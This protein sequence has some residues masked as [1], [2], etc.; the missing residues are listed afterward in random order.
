MFRSSFAPFDLKGFLTL[1]TNC[2]SNTDQFGNMFKLTNMSVLSLFVLLS[3]VLFA[4]GQKD[5]ENKIFK[6]PLTDMAASAE[7]VETSHYFPDHPDN[8]FPIGETFT[9]LCH[10]SNEGHSLYNVSA[11]M[12]SLNSPMDFRH[13]FQNYSYKPIGMVVKA[14]EE[15]SLE[16]SIP[17]HADL[18]PVEYQLAITVFYESETESFSTTFFNQ[19]CRAFQLPTQ[20]FFTNCSIF[21]QT[22]ELY[23]PVSEYDLE[24]VISVLVSIIFSVAVGILTL[25]ACSPDTKIPLFSYNKSEKNLNSYD[26]TVRIVLLVVCLR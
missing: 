8:K 20:M 6:H 14:G 2:V 10:F 18:E 12:G 4:V 19:V 3:I 23:S 26:T 1:L 11:I 13:H 9:A 21:L 7:D 25:M 5:E 16:Y 15:I 17:L 24:S 22:V